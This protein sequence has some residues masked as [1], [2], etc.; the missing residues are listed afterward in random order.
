MPLVP[1]ILASSRPAFLVDHEGAYLERFAVTEIRRPGRNWYDPSVTVTDP[2]KRKFPMRYRESAR[3]MDSG[4]FRIHPPSQVAF[5]LANAFYEGQLDEHLEETAQDMLSDEPEWMHLAVR[6]EGE[7]YVW[8]GDWNPRSVW[9][10]RVGPFEIHRPKEESLEFRSGK[11]PSHGM[12]LGE[13]PDGLSSWLTG[14]PRSKLADQVLETRLKDLPTQERD[15]RYDI[16][17]FGV[18]D[19]QLT[20]NAMSSMSTRFAASRGV[21]DHYTWIMS[22]IP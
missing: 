1:N 15:G 16:F 6:L 18:V 8:R 10:Y 19:G 9:S 12:T 13:A 20:L 22:M 5:K 4:L 2:T 7:E 17:T 14:L 11:L 21:T 3:R